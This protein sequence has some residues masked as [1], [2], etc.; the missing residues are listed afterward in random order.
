MTGS[1]SPITPKTKNT[2]PGIA[3]NTFIVTPPIPLSVITI[4]YIRS[5]SHLTDFLLFTGIRCMHSGDNDHCSDNL[6][7]CQ[8]F[9]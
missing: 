7:E 2:T 3:H 4:L 6:Q 8:S 5:Y 1:N 9:M